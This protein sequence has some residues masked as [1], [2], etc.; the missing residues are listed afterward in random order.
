MALLDINEAARVARRSPE[1][2][3]RWVWSGK[4]SAQRRGRRL[5]I[6][7]EDLVA[8]MAKQGPDTALIT[9]A[10]WADSARCALAS[11]GGPAHSSAADL[12]L[13]DRRERSEQ[14]TDPCP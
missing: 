9:L 11:S 3:R 4:L 8:L 6:V 2:V 12:V 14:P 10:D 7:Q 5:M 13:T 1:T